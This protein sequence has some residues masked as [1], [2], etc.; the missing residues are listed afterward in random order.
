MNL[1]KSIHTARGALE[2]AKIGQS[3]AIENNYGFVPGYELHNQL[4]TI[5]F[6]SKTGEYD[7]VF[8]IE[9]NNQETRVG[10]MDEASSVSFLAF[11]AKTFRESPSL[12]SYAN[13][14]VEDLFNWIVVSYIMTSNKLP[15]FVSIELFTKILE[16]EYKNI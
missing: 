16:K 6:L 4:C 3:F 7:Y 15:A 9:L 10:F 2:E 5:R 8:R 13:E 11:A 1:L 14:H 12:F